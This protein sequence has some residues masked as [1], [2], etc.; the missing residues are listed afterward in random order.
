MM[1]IKLKSSFKK[2][3]MV[4]N[5]DGCVFFKYNPK[6]ANLFPDKIY[7]VIGIEGD[8]YR[9]L[10]SDNVPELYCNIYFDIVPGHGKIPERW[11]A[12]CFE[13][14]FFAYPLELNRPGFFEDYF[15][16]DDEAISIFWNVVGPEVFK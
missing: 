4:Q 1:L 11:E 8:F 12:C 10:N 13:D 6:I 14:K 2:E 16:N 5:P 3:D 15:L 7:Y 9:V